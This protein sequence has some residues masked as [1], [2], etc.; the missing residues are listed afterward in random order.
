MNHIVFEYTPD[1]HDLRRSTRI[2]ILT[3]PLKKRKVIPTMFA[4]S[5]DVLFEEFRNLANSED[6]L[7]TQ[8]VVAS[9]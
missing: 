6:C 5:T 3:M 2:A 1:I 7:V 8:L 4:N 9:S